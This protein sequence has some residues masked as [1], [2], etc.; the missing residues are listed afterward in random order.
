ML[1]E[2]TSTTYLLSLIVHNNSYLQKHC[3]KAQHSLAVGTPDGLP[4]RYVENRRKA[5]LAHHVMLYRPYP[6]GVASRLATVIYVVMVLY[7][8]SHSPN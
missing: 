6:G 3:D 8:N 2:P 1:C 4:H 5:Q 7:D